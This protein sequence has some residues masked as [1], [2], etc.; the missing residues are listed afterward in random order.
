VTLI[1]RNYFAVQAF[2][3]GDALSS[4]FTPHRGILEGED[5]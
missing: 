1:H 4:F 3:T 2:C 5:I